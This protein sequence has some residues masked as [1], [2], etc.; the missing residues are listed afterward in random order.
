MK[1][2]VF[3]L[4]SMAVLFIFITSGASFSQPIDKE[5]LWGENSTMTFIMYRAYNT[6]KQIV[7]TLGKLLENDDDVSVCL[8][9]AEKTKIHPQNIMGLKRANQSW[10]Q[11]I[12]S[13][14]FEPSTI[15]TDAG[16]YDIFGVPHV[17]RHSYGEYKKWQKDAT[18]QMDLTDDDFRDLVQLRF[19]TKNYGV[20]LINAMRRR[21]AGE[22][23]TNMILGSGK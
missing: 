20:T 19:V 10:K 8:Y 16:I 23:W 6:D 13:I 22:S 3:N 21:N 14:S 12:K 11:I 1:K 17:F 5:T 15:F 18:Y 9:L 7:M 2:S 4:L